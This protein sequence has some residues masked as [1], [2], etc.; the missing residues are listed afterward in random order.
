MIDFIRGYV[1]YVSPE[2]VVVEVM[3]VGYQVNAPNPFIYTVNRDKEV[4][5]YTYQHVRED[6][7][8]LYGF[9]TRED[10]NLFMKLLNVTG[11]GPKGALAILAS[12]QPAQ[13]VHA[14]ENEDEKFLIKFPGV[15]KKTARQIILDLK[16]KL[17]DLVPSAFPDL[18]QPGV[19][20]P[21]SGSTN[22]VA[23]E[24]AMEAL[25]VLGYGDREI[26]KIVP[27]LQK[28][29]LTTDQYVKRAL[30]LLLK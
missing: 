7:L 17:N 10:K 9:K 12:G 28:E 23:L 4:T 25:Q 16:G 14:I 20:M 1:E 18:F 19:D 5:I 15:G 27:A 2:Y 22:N 24:E 21:A 3:G 29:E 26:K 30:Q 13:V 8:A 6:I 11:I